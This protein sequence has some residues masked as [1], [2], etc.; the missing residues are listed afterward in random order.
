MALN[1][2][3]PTHLTIEQWEARLIEENPTALNIPV[4]P[5]TEEG[6]KLWANQIIVDEPDYPG[7][8]T[9]LNWKDWAS[10]LFEL[11]IV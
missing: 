11:E 3:D 1:I 7:A 4:T 2:P 9:F 6:W 5:P 10:V 8:N